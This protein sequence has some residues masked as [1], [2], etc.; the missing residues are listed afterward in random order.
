MHRETDQML[1]T[2]YA[3]GELAGAEREAVEA[4]LAASAA[5]R[6][7]VEEVRAAARMISDEL[8]REETSGLE[9]IHYAAI[10]LQLR[11]AGGPRPVDRRAVVRERVAFAITLAASIVIGVGV[12]WLVLF[13]LLRQT[14]V[15]TNEP[16]TS[17]APV[18][19]PLESLPP[20]PTPAAAGFAAAPSDADPFVSAADHPVS[21]FGLNTDTASYDELRQALLESHLPLHGSIKIEGLINAFAYDDPAP[22]PGALFGA[23]IEIGQCPWT[24]Q[25]RLARIAV[26]ARPGEG[27]VAEDARTEVAFNPAAAKSYRL[28]GYEG[29][30]ASN[31]PTAMPGERVAAGQ[32][33]TALYEIVPAAPGAS[34]SDLLTLR[35]RF[36]RSVGGPEE[37][38]QFTGRDSRK[39]AETESP[40]FRF[41][42]A[43][44]EF[45][46]VMRNSPARG[47]SSMNE[48]IRLAESGRG[49][50]PAGERKR[51]I[52]LAQRAK[53]L[54]G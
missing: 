1:L 26:K 53:A 28:L 48:V 49:A 6:R 18:L 31:R 38:V 16:R 50:D 37:M 11:E 2:A 8:A 19:V 47:R 17:P 10:E 14:P 54:L 9:A 41:A 35:V 45:G 42:A 27:I 29:G 30:P 36:R 13:A 43:V 51:F 12:I 34:S 21:A 32:A 46:M 20:E 39:Q 33:V 4:R 7:F 22:A 24:P 25:N 52:E 3:L 23:G 40:D 5:D 15:A 44:A